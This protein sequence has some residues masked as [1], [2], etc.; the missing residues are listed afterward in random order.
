ML[1]RF[2]QSSYA[3]NDAAQDAGAGVAVLLAVSVPA[4]HH[5]RA[6]KYCSIWDSPGLYAVYGLAGHNS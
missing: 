3:T 1:S 2:H 5:F 4:R 6:F